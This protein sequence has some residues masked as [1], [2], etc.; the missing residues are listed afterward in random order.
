MSDLQNL[1]KQINEIDKELV[2]LLNK[3]FSVTSRIGRLKLE[4]QRP[5]Y[6]HDRENSVLSAVI[7]FAEPPVSSK[8]I[9]SIFR[10]IMQISNA[11]QER[12]FNK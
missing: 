10:H 9:E 11:I 1:R 3:R 6:D 2:R 4:K 5:I 7:S 8:E 12:E